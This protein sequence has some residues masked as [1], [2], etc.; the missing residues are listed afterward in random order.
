MAQGIFGGKLPRSLREHEECYLA[1][2]EELLGQ[3][4]KE[5]GDDELLGFLLLG[6][7]FTQHAMSLCPPD[8]LVMFNRQLRRNVICP[9]R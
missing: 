2:I 3:E 7:C 5:K 8:S 1:R 4:E 6:V 9:P